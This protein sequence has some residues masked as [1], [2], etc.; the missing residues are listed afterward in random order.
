LIIHRRSG[1]SSDRNGQRTTTVY[2]RRK[3]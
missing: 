1:D 2:R 3:Q